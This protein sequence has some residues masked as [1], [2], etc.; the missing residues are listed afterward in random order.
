MNSLLKI[1]DYV[2]ILDGTEKG[3]VIKLEK[4]KAWIETDAGFEI[5]SQINKLVKYKPKKSHMKIVA[6]K[7]NASSNHKTEPKEIPS[8]NKTIIKKVKDKDFQINPR[9]IGEEKKS[10]SSKKNNENIWEVDLHIEEITDSYKHLSN[11]EI[12]IIQL[13]HV[14]SIIEKARKNKI[15]KLIFIHGK[16][17]GTLRL[18]LLNLLRR[19]TFLEF[20]DASFKKYGAGATEVKIFV[21]KV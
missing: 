19:Y 4:N 17:K 12:V 20:Y 6:E 8:S 18:E 9:Q 7:S 21:N 3:F 13:Q 11:G 14:R 1:G 10:N 5:T 15:N 16:G 2:G